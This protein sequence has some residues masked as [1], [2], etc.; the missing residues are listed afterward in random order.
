MTADDAFGVPLAPLPDWARATAAD[1]DLD[2]LG[3]LVVERDLEA[4]FPTLAGNGEFVER[5]RASVAENLVALQQVLTGRLALSEVR[6][7]EPLV[8]A[9]VQARLRV[10]QTALQRSYRVG[11]RAMWQEWSDQLCTRAETEGVSRDEALAAHRSL[12]QALLAYQDHVASLVAESYARADDALSRS[13]AHVRS[14]LVRQLLQPDAPTPSPSDLVTLGYPLADT[15]VAVLLPTVAQGTA[16]RLAPGL[17]AASR[18][19][20]SLLHPIDLTGTVIWLASP[21]GWTSEATASL[22]ERLGAL[23]VV[24]SVSAARPGLDGLRETWTQ[25]QQVQQIRTAWGAARSPRVLRHA[26][27]GLEILL[28]QDPA[29]A[30]TFVTEELGPLAAATDQAGRL[31]ETLLVSLVLGSHVATAEQLHLHEHTVR[32]RLQKAEDLIGRPLQ[33][34]RT[35]LQVALRL[36]RLLDGDDPAGAALSA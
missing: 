24:A 32:N 14:A 22:Y 35:E 11:F 20:E 6:L 12:T 7:D 10:P 27:V 23:D 18:A 31:R 1:V 30:R 8:F 2:T 34:R 26:D 19:T 17:R 3:A 28:M 9:T 33:G 21:A 5:L 36:I 13:R 15:H 25:V 29:Q 4:A 16:E